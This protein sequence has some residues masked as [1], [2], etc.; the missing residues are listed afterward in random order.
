MHFIPQ[1]ADL[2]KDEVFLN[3]IRVG[4]REYIFDP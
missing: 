1:A 3:A 2:A 4:V